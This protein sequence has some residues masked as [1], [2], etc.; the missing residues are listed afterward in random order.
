M[1]YLLLIHNNPQALEGL[2]DEERFQLIGGER[3]ATRI[4]E[5]QRDGELINVLALAD[6]SSSRTVQRRDGAPVVSDR[7]FLETKEFLAGALL[8]DC[9][10]MERAVEIAAELPYAAVQRIEI[11]P[12]RTLEDLDLATAVGPGR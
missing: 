10:T 12:T 9:P 1:K 3:L 2:S 4:E 6:P 11:R 5:L 8:L 7:P